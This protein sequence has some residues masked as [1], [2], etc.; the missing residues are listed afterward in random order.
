MAIKNNS[1][2]TQ[3]QKKQQ[4]QD[5]RKKNMEQV[6]QLLTPEQKLKMKNRQRKM[7]NQDAS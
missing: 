2:L 3:E 1:S 4:M 6:N 7:K 5:L